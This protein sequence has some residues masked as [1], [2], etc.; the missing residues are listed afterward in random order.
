MTKSKHSPVTWPKCKLVIAQVR[1]SSSSFWRKV[2]SLYM[3]AHSL[4]SISQAFKCWDDWP[5]SKP[6]FLLNI[7]IVCFFRTCRFELAC[8]GCFLVCFTWVFE[9]TTNRRML[10]SPHLVPHLKE[11]PPHIMDSSH[12]AITPES[13]SSLKHALKC[14]SRLSLGQNF[15]LWSYLVW[16]ILCVQSYASVCTALAFHDPLVNTRWETWVCLCIGWQC[17]ACYCMAGLHKICQCQSIHFSWSL[18]SFN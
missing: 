3:H 16:I 2:C 8:K 1:R 13:L 10:L 18:T 14:L 9:T 6:F 7:E 4:S 12:I 11:I 5:I 15:G 17:I